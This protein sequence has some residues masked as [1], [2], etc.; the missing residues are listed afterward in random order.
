[1]AGASLF[2]RV[3]AGAEPTA[4][5]FARLKIMQSDP[6]RV[7]VLMLTLI[8]APDGLYL[9]PFCDP[10]TMRSEKVDF[11]LTRTDL[12]SPGYGTG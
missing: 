2:L 4:H 11:S 6:E 5:A 12:T 8:Y 9:P 3:R 10:F 1:M 7:H